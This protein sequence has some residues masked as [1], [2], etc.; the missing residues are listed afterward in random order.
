MLGSAA[1][2]AVLLQAAAPP[3]EPARA[4]APE[5]RRL[6]TVREFVLR[7]DC[8]SEAPSYKALWVSRDSGRTWKAAKDAGVEAAWGEW[9]AGALRCTL[10]VA[11]DGL[12]DLFPQIGDS[13]SNRGPEP[14][15]GTPA[16]PRLRL[17]IREPLK[18]AHLEWAEPRAATEWIGGSTVALKWNAVEPDFLARSAELQYALEDGPWMRITK[19]LE[20]T[21]QYSWVVP[22]RPALRLRLRVTARTRAGLESAAETE[23]IV[24][25]ASQRPDIVKARALYDRAR[26]LHAQQRV[27]EARLKYQEALAAWPEFGEIY[28]DL[29]KLHAEQK[30]P[31][32]ALEYF[33]RARAC[34][35]SDPVPVVNA[36]RQETELGLH[37]D[38]VEDLRAAVALGLEGDE[39]AAVLAGE[40]LW[41]VARTASL[42]GE[43]DR[44]RAACELLLK[45]RLAARPT[46]ARAQQMIEWM[47]GR[48]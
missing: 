35:P 6:I 14:V 43:P 25:V 46:R 13:V 24:L 31:A 2:V 33:N 32:K 41:A 37:E 9:T 40:T 36:A 5:Q 47:A 7:I 27:A 12:Y 3:Q 42:A 1:V 10:K 28:N 23:S 17:E 4:S 30:E 38:A 39:R 11:E 21:G 44:A 8:K 16:D 18:V 45:I 48:K 29:G 26:V 19:G 34:C 20:A 22:N 15:A